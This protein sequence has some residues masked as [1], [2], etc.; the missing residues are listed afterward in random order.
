[1]LILNCHILCPGKVEHPMESKFGCIILNIILSSL[2]HVCSLHFIKMLFFFARSFSIASRRHFAHIS[3]QQ[4]SF[5]LN[6]FLQ[7]MCVKDKSGILFSP[8][9]ISLIWQKFSCKQKMIL[10]ISP[11][12][13]CHLFIF[14]QQNVNFLLEIF[15]LQIH[16]LTS[17]THDITHHN[18]YYPTLLSF[19]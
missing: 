3:Y 17:N 10:K 9:E 11:R 7:Q 16:P 2:S 5:F 15:V 8:M 1:L 13:I 18:I 14:C 12:M 6:C 19:F 4:L